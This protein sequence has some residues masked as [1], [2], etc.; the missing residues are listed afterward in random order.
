MS[1][2]QY[3]LDAGPIVLAERCRKLAMCCD[4]LSA[5]LVELTRI[6][7]VACD[8]TVARCKALAGES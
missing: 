4:S 7:R 1:D 8:A 2:G 6:M 3:T 5:C